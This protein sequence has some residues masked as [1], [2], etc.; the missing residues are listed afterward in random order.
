MHRTTVFATALVAATMLSGCIVVVGDTDDE[1]GVETGWIGSYDEKAS[2]RRESNVELA[3][4]VSR[5]LDE[6]P[7]LQAEDITVS[8]SGEVVTLFGRL[9]DIT[10]LQQAVAA[11]GEVEGVGRVVSRITLDVR[12]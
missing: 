3:D 4:R 6:I 10:A 9:H 12:S 1:S 11:A 7:A 2:A 8:A 5:R